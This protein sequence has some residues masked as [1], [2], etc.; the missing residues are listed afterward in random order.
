M[1]LVG[2]R[3]S[4]IGQSVRLFHIRSGLGLEAVDRVQAV[5]GGP[6]VA[7]NS[8]VQAGS[9]GQL[10][11]RC[12]RSLRTERASHAGTLM[13]WA[14]IVPMVARAWNADARHPAA[15]VRLNAIAASTRHAELAW[16]DPEGT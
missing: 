3:A 8:W 13:S 11:D 1:I 5:A 6:R 2:G 4:V 15:R 14:R 10:V 7:S 9:Q 16:S 12:I